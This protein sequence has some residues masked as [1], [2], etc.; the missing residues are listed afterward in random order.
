[1]SL[2]LFSNKSLTRLERTNFSREKIKERSDLQQA[3]LKS[4]GCIAPDCLVIA[5][6]FSYW[7]ESQCRID[8]LAIDRKGNLVVVELKRGE[9]GSHMELQALRYAAMVAEM[10]FDKACLSYLHYC[11]TH[12]TPMDAPKARDTLLTFIDLVDPEDVETQFGNDVRTILVS[13]GFSKEST[14]TV[15]WLRH[16]GLDISCIKLTPYL[17]GRQVLISI[18][19]IIPV[20]E[21]AEYQIKFRMKEKLER[22]T[23]AKSRRRDMTRYHYNGEW[24]NKRR[25]AWK[26]MKDYVE[27]RQP[28]TL[29]ELIAGLPAVLKPVVADMDTLPEKLF[30]RFHTNEEDILFLPN[31]QR[32]VISTQ[33]GK[34][35][36]DDIVQFAQSHLN[37]SVKTEGMM[38]E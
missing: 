33:W 37:V 17:S 25:L 26:V 12:N 13:E 28:E 23:V 2:Y 4:I 6:E 35:N 34:G 22:D 24:Y 27:H 18:E 1:M 7:D 38:N 31:Q 19:Q 29:D 30:C 32:V 3:L 36:I 10:D 11:R 8:I 16:N 5:E 20:P 15:L 14:T 9:S 21:E